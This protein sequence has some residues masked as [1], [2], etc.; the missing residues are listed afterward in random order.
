MAAA[1]VTG[2]VTLM[3]EKDPSL[4][5]DTVKAR[6]MRSATKVDFADVF[7]TLKRASRSLVPRIE[8]IPGVDKVQARVVAYVNID[9]EGFSDP[10][11]GHLVSLPEE[12]SGLLN[13]VYLRD[14]R[15][16]EPGRDDEVLECTGVIPEGSPSRRS[17]T[18]RR[19]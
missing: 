18:N 12:G 17:S 11:S 16:P 7:A 2:A 1:V 8:A 3:L 14:G 13:Q 5:P 10:A 19:R 6:L 4:T 15:L 9:V